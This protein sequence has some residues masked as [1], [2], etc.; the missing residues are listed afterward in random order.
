MLTS[1]CKGACAIAAASA[2]WAGAAQADNQSVLIV[3]GSYFPSTI[4]A[5]P[6]DN[7]IFTNQSGVVQHISGPEDTWTSGP[8]G[9]DA[10]YRLNLTHSTPLSFTNGEDGEGLMEGAISYD[11]APL[12][13]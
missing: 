7:V 6:G 1:F 2:L 8:I 10:T 5:K 4:Y 12:N 13:D 11:P 9:V 3:E